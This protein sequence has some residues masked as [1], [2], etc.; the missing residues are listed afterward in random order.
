MWIVVSRRVCDNDGDNN[1]DHD[2]DTETGSIYASAGYSDTDSDCE[3]GSEKTRSLLYR[4]STILN[5]ANGSP[6]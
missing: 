2:S 4:Q 5:V 1:N 6:R 3:T